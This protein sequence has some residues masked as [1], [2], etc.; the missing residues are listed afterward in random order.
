MQLRK[1][2]LQ[3]SKDTPLEKFEDFFIA[4]ASNKAATENFSFFQ[5]VS[6]SGAAAEMPTPL[7]P[8]HL[9]QNFVRTKQA[10]LQV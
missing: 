8:Y 9:Q 6:F 1:T 10:K 2:V 7:C 4:I 3:V 5:V